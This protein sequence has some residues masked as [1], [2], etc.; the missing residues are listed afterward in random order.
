MK[1]QNLVDHGI[2]FR[3]VA[4]EMHDDVSIIKSN[5]TEELQD[6]LS[7]PIAPHSIAVERK[8][9]DADNHAC[10]CKNGC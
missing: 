8:I 1:P 10:N 9:Q 6:E 4:Q 2:L 3:S 7:Y 5:H